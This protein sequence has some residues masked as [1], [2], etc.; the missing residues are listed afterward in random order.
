MFTVTT[1]T[2]VSTFPQL[3]L[4]AT[5]SHCLFHILFII[6]HLRWSWLFACRVTQTFCRAWGI[7]SPA[8]VVNCQFPIGFNRRVWQHQ[9]MSWGFCPP[10]LSLL[11]PLRRWQTCISLTH[12]KDQNKMQISFYSFTGT[13]Q[14][15]DGQWSRLPRVSLSLGKNQVDQLRWG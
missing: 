10:G 9:V 3:V 2:T 13:A 14:A 7:S 1:A 12:Y 6:K 4:T 11:C 5:V 15:R 8:G